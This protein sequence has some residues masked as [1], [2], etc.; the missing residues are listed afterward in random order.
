MPSQHILYAVLNWG[1]GHATRSIPIIR[2]LTARGHRVTLAGEGDALVLLRQVFPE[3]PATELRGI[4]VHYPL[5]LPL[6]ASMLMQSRSILRA[7]KAEKAATE[8]LVRTLQPDLII[9]DNRYGT[10]SDTV[11]SYLIC[12]QLQLLMPAGLRLLGGLTRALYGQFF[13]PFRQIWVPDLA[14]PDN[15]TGEL[16]HF[17]GAAKM[18]VRYIGPLSRLADFPAADIPERYDVFAVISGPEP[19]RSALEQMLTTALTGLPESVLLVRGQPRKNEDFQQQNIRF[20]SHLPPGAVKHHFLHAGKIISR[21]GHSTLMDLC[22]VRRPAI[23]IPTPG[24]T[25]QE[26]LARLHAAAGRIVHV[27]QKNP[28]LHLALNQ[29]PLLKPFDFPVNEGIDK[30]LA[31]ILPVR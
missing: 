4:N 1:L 25:E 21:S 6:A 3:L 31:E 29:H 27:Q 18:N 22:A 23:C 16:S 12:H 17:T 24:Q 5:H 13:Q 20:V 30:I 28:A 2:A 9:S 7:I 10:W 8:K 26:Y 19:Q 11:P 15:I 14:G